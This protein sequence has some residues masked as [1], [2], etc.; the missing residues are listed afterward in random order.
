[1]NARCAGEVSPTTAGRSAC[2]PISKAVEKAVL[3]DALA[4]STVAAPYQPAC[5]SWSAINHPVRNSG[6]TTTLASSWAGANPSSGT[7]RR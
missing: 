1:M 3:L 7:A 2:P 4:S 5:S 6:R